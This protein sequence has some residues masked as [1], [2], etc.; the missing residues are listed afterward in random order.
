MRYMYIQADAK[1]TTTLSL[2]RKGKKCMQSQPKRAVTASSGCKPI[3]G[4]RR[5]R[6]C[7]YAF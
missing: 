4:R 7:F 1:A 3:I 6:K 2:R 5:R